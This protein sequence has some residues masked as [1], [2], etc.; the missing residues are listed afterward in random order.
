MVNGLLSLMAYLSSEYFATGKVPERTGNDHPLVAPYGLF[1]SADGQIA[2]AP[3]HDQILRR[4]LDAL[5]L[6]WVLSEPRYDN[7]TARMARHSELRELIEAR[8]AGQPRDH[9]LRVLNTAG[10]PCGVVQDLAQ[11]FSDPQIAAQ[12]MVIET[13]WQDGLAQKVLGFPIKLGATPCNLHRPVPRLG[14][15]TQEVLAEAGYSAEEIARLADAG[16]V[17][18]S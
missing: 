14:G 5:D 4:F 2:V 1:R 16:T 12:Q 8:M 18:R 13:G 7:N 15:G 10:V 17:L 6:G 11:V 9:W 3:S